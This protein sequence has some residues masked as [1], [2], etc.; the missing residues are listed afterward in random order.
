MICAAVGGPGG[1]GFREEN[2]DDRSYQLGLHVPQSDGSCS[3]AIK[4]LRDAAVDRGF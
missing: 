1:C 3:R 2:V 4:R